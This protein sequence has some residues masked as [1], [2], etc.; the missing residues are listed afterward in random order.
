MKRVKMSLQNIE[1]RLSRDEMKKIM[2][3]SADGRPCMTCSSDND[4]AKVNKGKCSAT[5]P[6][7]SKACSGWS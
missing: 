6:D 3:G 4:C 7:G 5:C 1:G 2:A